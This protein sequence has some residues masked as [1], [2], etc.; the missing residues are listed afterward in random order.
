[1]PNHQY[2]E[3]GASLPTLDDI[4]TF[5]PHHFNLTQV[6]HQEEGDLIKTVVD[7][8]D[9]LRPPPHGDDAL[10]VKDTVVPEVFDFTPHQQTGTTDVPNQDDTC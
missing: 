2:Q 3:P 7:G 8:D 10:Q 1:M 5:F 4:Q 9:T 6:Y